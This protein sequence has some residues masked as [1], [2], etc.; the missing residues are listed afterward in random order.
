MRQHQPSSLGDDTLS[1]T[2]ALDWC[3]ISEW[4]AAIGEPQAKGGEHH[5]INNPRGEQVSSISFLSNGET[6][7][8]RHMVGEGVRRFAWPYRAAEG[9]EV[10][11]I[12]NPQARIAPINSA[13]G[14]ARTACIV[15]M[16]YF[17]PLVEHGGGN[18]WP[19]RCAVR[20]S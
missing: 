18:A 17:G 10:A 2:V 16:K 20:A 4:L 14:R 3:A 8:D 1:N 11:H 13:K 9:L 6:N 19:Y 12:A 5:V 7:A 15:T